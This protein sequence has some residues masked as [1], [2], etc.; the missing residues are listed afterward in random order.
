MITPSPPSDLTSS[1]Q[2]AQE[3]DSKVLEESERIR[4]EAMQFLRSSEMQDE[5]NYE[6][7][8]IHLPNYETGEDFESQIKL[9]TS[10][11]TRNKD[12]YK[13][14]GHMKSIILGLSEK[15]HI[16]MVHRE[17]VDI[18]RTQLQDSIA[19]RMELEASIEETTEQLRN[20]S[21]AVDAKLKDLLRE[22]QEQEAAYDDTVRHFHAGQKEIEDLTA[23]QELLNKTITL[24]KGKVFNFADMQALNEKVRAQ[25]ADSEKTRSN[26]QNAMKSAEQEFAE[27]TNRQ[28]HLYSVMNTEKANLE[29]D[30]GKLRAELV[31]Q[32]EQKTEEVDELKRHAAGELDQV[33]AERTDEI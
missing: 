10:A 7:A 11:D 33:Q 17:E 13:E 5:T 26:L 15:L 3:I 6:S 8:N 23:E 29:G 2:R 14:L 12:Y 4:A 28:I 30:V 19:S 25:L 22:K 32:S 1:I 16:N 24:L 31:S 21:L 9:H 20:E 27:S 18:L